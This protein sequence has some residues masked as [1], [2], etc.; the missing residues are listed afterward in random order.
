MI[1]HRIVL[2]IALLLAAGCPS[3]DS[4]SGPVDKCTNTGQQCRMGGGQL[5][6]CTMDTA[7]DYVCASQH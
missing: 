3:G 1:I 5:G 2:S 4:S 7:G 6:V